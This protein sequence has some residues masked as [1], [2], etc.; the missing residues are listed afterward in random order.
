MVHKSKTKMGLC[1]DTSQM[2]QSG[3]ETSASVIHG[4]CWANWAT[5]MP[6]GPY[7][8]QFLQWGPEKGEIVLTSKHKL[9]VCNSNVQNSYSRQDRI[10][11]SETPPC[12]LGD[13]VC[14]SGPRFLFMWCTT[15]C[16]TVVAERC[17]MLKAMNVQY[18]SEFMPLCHI[19]RDGNPVWATSCCSFFTII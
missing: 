14:S 17:I 18:Y 5:R 12:V 13:S 15:W 2:S 6:W 1:V 4:N 11:I 16:Y 3:H 10:F 9:C 7:P 19:N 8:W